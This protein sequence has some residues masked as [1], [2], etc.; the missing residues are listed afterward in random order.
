M[1]MAECM[2]L[3]SGIDFAENA[4]I[5]EVFLKNKEKRRDKNLDVQSGGEGS[6][7]YI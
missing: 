2:P 3:L 5:F 4:G 1:R 6:R 7:T